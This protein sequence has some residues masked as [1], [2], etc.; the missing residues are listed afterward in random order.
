MGKIRG[1]RK[2]RERHYLHTLDL[3]MRPFESGIFLTAF[4]DL[5]FTDYL[6]SRFFHCQSA[7]NH[8]KRTIMGTT[9]RCLKH[10]KQSLNE[11]HTVKQ[12]V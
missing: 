11:S 10:T 3:E 7:A 1:A 12:T 9:S 6:G 2:K 5:L 4:Q 8:T